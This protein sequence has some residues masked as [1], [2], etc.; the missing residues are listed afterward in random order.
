MTLGRVLG[1]FL[2]FPFFV[3]YKIT[4]SPEKGP[5]YI[6][7]KGELNLK[8]QRTREGARK[9]FPKVLRKSPFLTKVLVEIKP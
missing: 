8:E 1:S 9:L 7:G 6:R 5:S 2:C 4:G 3:K